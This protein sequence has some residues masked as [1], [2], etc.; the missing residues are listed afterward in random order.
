MMLTITHTLS[1]H[2][3]PI[4]SVKH[5]TW[6]KVMLFS[7]EG[8]LDLQQVPG[9]VP[10]LC[11]DRVPS[12]APGSRSGTA[13]I[14]SRC[15][16][17]SGER[18]HPGFPPWV[19]NHHHCSRGPGCAAVGLRR[20]IPPRRSCESSWATATHSPLRPAPASCCETPGPCQSCLIQSASVATI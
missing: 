1:S 12:L 17:G 4:R 10:V 13:G 18:R 2:R 16:R 11:C 15:P 3:S 6:W 14:A 8:P 19:W 20:N 5:L 7:S 9:P